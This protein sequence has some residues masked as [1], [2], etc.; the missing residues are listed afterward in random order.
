MNFLLSSMWKMPPFPPLFKISLFGKH[1]SDAIVFLGTWQCS[2]PSGSLANLCS[3]PPSSERTGVCA[4]LV[5]EP[6]HS[7][8]TKRAGFFIIYSYPKMPPLVFEQALSC[9]VSGEVLQGSR[10]RHKENVLDQERS[11]S[12][13]SSNATAGIDFTGGT[14]TPALHLSMV[15]LPASQHFSVILGCGGH[16]N[17]PFMTGLLS[18]ISLDFINWRL[19]LAGIA[20]I[21][22]LKERDRFMQLI[23]VKPEICRTR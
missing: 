12:S 10:H 3:V 2:D 20:V 22:S 13:Q 16:F 23:Y 14:V 7:P 9:S 4:V 1:I 5:C 6:F 21:Y 18:L 11:H 17:F 8:C 19:A 15:F